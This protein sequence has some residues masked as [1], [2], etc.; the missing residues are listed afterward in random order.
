MSIRNPLTAIKNSINS[1]LARAYYVK[2]LRDTDQTVDFIYKEITD[3]L[4]PNMFA[5][6]VKALIRDM[7]TSRAEQ[8]NFFS[9]QPDLFHD[10]DYQ[11]AFRRNDKSVQCALGDFTLV[12][13]LAVEQRKESH[14]VAANRELQRFR[15]HAAYIKPLLQA[16]S[17]WRW[18]DAVAHLEKNGGLPTI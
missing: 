1:A 10:L 9:D 3:L 4:H 14:V 12:E 2:K 17:D 16:N 13:V 8:T 5:L 15:D 11:Y 18:R 7:I 6:M